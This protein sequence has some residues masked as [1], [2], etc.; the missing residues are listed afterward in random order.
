MPTAGV[1]GGGAF[2][3]AMAYHIA[4]AGNATLLWAR[5]AA[6]RPIGGG[7]VW[8][9]QSTL[10]GASRRAARTLTPLCA[11]AQHPAQPAPDN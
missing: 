4:R 9:S 6:V 5:E 11:A 7:G 10:G 8:R 1:I 2:G 3:T